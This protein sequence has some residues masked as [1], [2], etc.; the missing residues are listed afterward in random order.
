MDAFDCILSL[1]Y[2]KGDAHLGRTAIQKLVYMAGHQIPTITTPNYKMQY[3]G[4]FSEELGRILERLVS[5]SF[6]SENMNPGGHHEA[7][8]YSLSEDG[9]SMA[10]ELEN[11]PEFAKIKSFMSV[12]K[13]TCNFDVAALSYASKILYLMDDRPYSEAVSGAKN[14]D[15]RLYRGNIQTGINTLQ[16]L[17]L[18]SP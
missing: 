3:Y 18:V 12:C 16:E 5:T 15:W 1:L 2:H 13:E 14:S 6:V 9:T 8:G 11:E 4:P 7:Y 17:G 10:R